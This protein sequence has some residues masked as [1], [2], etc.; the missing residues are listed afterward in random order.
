MCTNPDCKDHK[1]RNKEKFRAPDIDY[2]AAKNV[3]IA[4]ISNK[5]K[6][7]KFKRKKVQ[8]SVAAV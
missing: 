2:N 4:P 6:G 3:L 1:N 5:K 8:D 7:D